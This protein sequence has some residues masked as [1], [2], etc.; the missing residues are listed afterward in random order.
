[1]WQGWK[2][3]TSPETGKSKLFCLSV[4]PEEFYDLSREQ[5]DTAA[6]LADTLATHLERCRWYAD[7][8]QL[9]RS[10]STIHLSVKLKEQ[11]RAQGY[12]E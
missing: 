2:L 3:I 6:E 9:D 10:S 11:L 1:M 7:R 8:L 5:H 4:D 12:I